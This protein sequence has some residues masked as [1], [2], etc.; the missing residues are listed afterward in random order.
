MSE[1][2]APPTMTSLEPGTGVRPV[3]LTASPELNGVAGHVTSTGRVPVRI[4]STGVTVGIRPEKLEVMKMKGVRLAASGERVR[5]YAPV[6]V[7]PVVYAAGQ[8]SP[9]AHM[10][11]VPLMIS[12]VAPVRAL[13]SQADHDNQ[14]TTWFMIEP[15]SGFAPPRWQTYVGPTVLF[16]ADGRDLTPDDV[17]F[18]NSVFSSVLD[19]YGDGDVV[20]E[21]DFTPAAF[22]RWRALPWEGLKITL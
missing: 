13:V 5:S 7:D 12:R 10:F 1:P 3:G 11:G 18:L 17:S 21:R 16:L 4:L 9:V 14:H 8:P 22:A 20:P 19:D 2:A 6:D 15:K